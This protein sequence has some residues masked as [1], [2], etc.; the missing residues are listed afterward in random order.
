MRSDEWQTGWPAVWAG[1]SWEREE[2]ER[3]AGKVVR[4]G[5][6]WVELR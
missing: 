1:A 3:E 2:R 5:E 6:V 4:V